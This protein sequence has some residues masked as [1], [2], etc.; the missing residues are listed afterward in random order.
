MKVSELSKRSGVTLPTI[1]Y[2][3]RE[4]LLHAGESTAPNQADYE[5]SHLQR[6]AL[7]RSLREVGGLSVD[8]IRATVRSIGTALDERFL[9]ETIDT[10][11]GE[12]GSSQLTPAEA[13]EL[14]SARDDLESFFA[15][16]GWSVREE[17]AAK[18]ALAHAVAA[19]RRLANPE[20]IERDLDFYVGIAEEIASYEISED[21]RPLENPEEAL[22]SAIVGIVLLQP[23]I[24]AL[25]LLALEHRTRALG[26]TGPSDAAR[27]EAR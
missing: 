8:Q 13:E 2:Y 26:T 5:E 22:R 23:V 11:M 24:S 16:R 27:A 21:W 10:L 15:G 18:E 25:R 12:D 1:R 14:T 19:I 9:C 3:I 17:S 6:L 4:G 20:F 7:I